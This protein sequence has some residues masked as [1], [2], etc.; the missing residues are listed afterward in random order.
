MQD[1]CKI[2]PI[3]FGDNAMTASSVG[4]RR[5]VCED[6]ESVV[7]SHQVLKAKANQACFLSEN[8]SEVDFKNCLSGL[9]TVQNF[10]FLQFLFSFLSLFYIV[11]MPTVC[12][13][14]KL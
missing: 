13:F 9:Q 14:Y 10:E 7:G 12:T 5:A 8:G 4:L 1:A 11:S 2:I 3:A 6:E